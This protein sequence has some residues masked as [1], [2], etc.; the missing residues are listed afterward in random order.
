MTEA[1]EYK[2][3]EYTSKQLNIIKKA[4]KFKA[5]T[6]FI[7]ILINNKIFI[8]NYETSSLLK[9]TIKINKKNNYFDFHCN[10]ETILYVCDGTNVA[11]YEIENQK[12]KVLC[13]IEGHFTDVIYA[14]FDPFKPNIFL[15]V[16]ENHM[17]KI[18]NITDNLSMNIINLD[19]IFDEEINFGC[20]KI[21]VLTEKNEIIYFEYMNFNKKNIKKYSENKLNDI[22]YFHF[23]ND[24]LLIVI[25]S[26]SIELV[27]NCNKTQQYNLITKDEILSTFYSTKKKILIIIYLQEIQGFYINNENQI[28]KIFIFQ[29]SV[30]NHIIKPIY[31]KENLLNQNE[32]CKINQSY[33]SKIISFS[34]INNSIKPN[35]N[36][37]ED[38]N[39]K[40]IIKEIKKNICDI[41]LLLSINNNDY[42][43]NNCSK[44]KKYFEI[45]EIK[46][47][48]I[49]IKNRN[50]L[51]R[52]KFV[53]DSLKQLDEIFEIQKK[54]IFLLKLLINDN[55]NKELVKKYLEFLRDNKEE[56]KK[57]FIDYFEEFED[58][59][60]YNSKVLTVEEK[61]QLYKATVESEKDKFLKLFDSIN[62]YNKDKNEDLTK[63]RNYLKECDN[64][65]E[66]D[67]S[68]FNMN[69][70]LLNNELFYY[71]NT[72]LIKYNLKI[73]YNIIKEK[74]SNKD[75]EYLLKLELKKIQANL[76]LCKDYIKNS[77]DLKKINSIIISFIFCKNN[78]EFKSAF[79]LITL[80]NEDIN[81]LIKSNDK[82][83]IEF[84]NIYEYIDI[85][86]EKIK[87]FFKNVLPL[88][89]FKSIFLTLY[90]NDEYYPFQNK[91]FTDKFVEDSFEVL[92]I[93]LENDLGLTDKFTMK[94]YFI[95]FLSKINTLCLDSEKKILRNGSFVKT[96]SH[97]IGHN[98]VNIKFFME[99][100]QISIE[101]PRKKSI[102][103]S[104]G[105]I[106]VELALFGRALDEINLNE[107]LYILNEKN[108]EKT[109][110]DFQYGFNNIK[111]ENLKVEGVFGDLCKNI[112]L[113]QNYINNAR[114]I[115]ITSHL[116]H[117][118]E[119]K[120]Y[121]KNRNDVIGRGSSNINIEFTDFDN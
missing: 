55:T 91:E 94:T 57:I 99:N 67:I 4:D 3:E 98:F 106:Y 111:I 10:N 88:E 36:K 83:I 87:Q 51:K 38:N 2:I 97:E 80:A 7:L 19:V 8:F 95:P 37:L 121:C 116:S 44:S 85:K 40:I 30:E 120:I 113:D 66:N 15:T 53:E 62:G 11:I 20:E 65:F 26:A 49:L 69:L 31:I 112:L 79:N 68:F 102:K 12:V 56:L 25:T 115:F 50:L 27:E 84:L 107:A 43:S 24:D 117:G 93:P 82:N 33:S 73:L 23:L 5:N 42:S 72:N 39:E 48:L 76:N 59:L 90:G 63:F 108:Y 104:E 41:P 16:S 96:G 54:Y 45:D 22:K 14:S 46:K 52:K 21:G 110:I 119:K 86:L 61:N 6:K 103:D 13:V 70:N 29:Q 114:S 58:E 78:D 75:I 60:D 71:R 101:T 32:I 47:E 18:Y 118:K 100:C 92:N 9:E 77:S 64:Y 1:Y 81:I 109:F 74:K 17:I 34:I 105:G 35:N 89:C 28:E